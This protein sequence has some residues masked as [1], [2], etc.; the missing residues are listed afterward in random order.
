[1][2]RELINFITEDDIKREVDSYQAI[3]KFIKEN[4]REGEDFGK[5]ADYPKPSLLKP[6]AEKLCSLLNLSAH[7]DIIEKVENFRE[8]IFHY[9]CKCTLK[10]NFGIIVSEGLGSCN[11]KEN[12]FLNQNPYG[13]ANTVLKLAKKRALVD[14][15]LTATRTS[16]MFTQDIED[17]DEVISLEVE[18]NLATSSQ[19]AF[20]AKLAKDKGLTEAQFI[21]FTKKITGKEKSKEWTK[22]DAAKIIKTLKN[23]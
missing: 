18:K 13:I 2:E 9:V 6:G 23:K 10:N 20:I 5:I 11:S 17:I 7:V 4:F 21:E 15:I 22:E 8:G 14:A 19:K 1:M 12:K 3:I 16:G